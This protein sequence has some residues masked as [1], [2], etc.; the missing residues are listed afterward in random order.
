M[1]LIRGY[2]F[3]LGIV[4]SLALGGT[5]ALT[6]GVGNAAA[7][8]LPGGTN[9]GQCAAALGVTGA[10][11]NNTRGGDAQAEGGN[12]GN[13]GLITTV[14]DVGNAEAD[15]SNSVTVHDITTG[16]ATAADINVD[17]EGATRPVVV[18]VAGSFVDTGVD[19]FA[20]GGSSQ[21]GTTGGNGIIAD[22]SGGPGGDAHADGG[23][24]GGVLSLLAGLI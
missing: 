11:C 20:P 14:H 10:N 2:M 21:A 18:S 24:G 6:I 5:A 8:L 3:V 22:S 1:R 15:A 12:G 17:A 7:Q 23:N 9:T 4:A 19:V 16:D 13:G